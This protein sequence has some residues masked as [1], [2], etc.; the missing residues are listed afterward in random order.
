MNQVIIFYH[1]TKIFGG[2]LY[3]EMGYYTCH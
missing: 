2:I 3:S 1:Q